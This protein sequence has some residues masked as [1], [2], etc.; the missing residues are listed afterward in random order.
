MNT[1]LVVWNHEFYFAIYWECFI[2]TDEV[3]FFRGVGIPP[4]RYISLNSSM[5]IKWYWD[6]FRHT[7][8]ES[9]GIQVFFFRWRRL[10]FF[11]TATPDFIHLHGDFTIK[12]R[13][14]WPKNQAFA[15]PQMNWSRTPDSIHDSC[16]LGAWTCIQRSQTYHDSL[17]GVMLYPLV[18]IQ[19][20]MENHRF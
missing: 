10:F 8:V 5:N 16:G 1:W 18:S 17:L 12:K 6:W 19:K 13:G 2:P 9:G 15:S 7:N 4:T 20:T 11:R 14:W 3:I